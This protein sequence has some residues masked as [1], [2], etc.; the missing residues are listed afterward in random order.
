[1]IT[2]Y[3]IGTQYQSRGKHPRLCTVK[4]VWK[5]YN[6]AGELVQIRYVTTHEFLGQIV[7]EYDVVAVTIARNLVGQIAI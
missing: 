3:P 4:D 5:T 6:A 2:E 7:T 1:M